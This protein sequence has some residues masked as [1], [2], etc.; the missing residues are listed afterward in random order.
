MFEIFS[1][2]AC[3]TSVN[4]VVSRARNSLQLTRTDQQKVRDCHDVS[5]QGT[6]S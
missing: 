6:Y 4:E 2:Q 1:Y 3:Q 5:Q